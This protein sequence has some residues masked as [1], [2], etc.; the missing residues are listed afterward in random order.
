ME[1]TVTK[2]LVLRVKTGDLSSFR[3]LYEAFHIKVFNFCLLY[4]KSKEDAEEIVQD[5]FVKIWQ[6]KHELDPERSING[7]VFRIAKNLALNRLRK[8]VNPGEAALPL[9]E[10]AKWLNQT[11]EEVL[12]HEMEGLLAEAIE[13]LPPKRQEIFKMSRI[14]GLSHEQIATHLRIS[15]QTVKGQIR[16]AIKYLRSY[17]EFI[18]WLTLFLINLPGKGL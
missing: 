3:I 10:K 18:S 4:L 13:G 9:Y 5:T 11:E 6:H 1:H 7:Y 12:F 8:K 2:K 16:K 15:E 14:N 17:I